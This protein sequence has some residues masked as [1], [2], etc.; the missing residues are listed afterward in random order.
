MCTAD[1]SLWMIF[2]PKHDADKLVTLAPEL[3]SHIGG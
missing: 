2:T 3:G 1:H